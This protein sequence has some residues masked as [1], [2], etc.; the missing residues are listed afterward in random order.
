MTNNCMDQGEAS[1]YPRQCSPSYPCWKDRLVSQPDPAR[2]AVNYHYAGVTMPVSNQLLEDAG[3]GEVE[4]I[5]LEQLRP[6]DFIDASNVI[7]SNVIPFPSKPD[8]RTTTELID[9]LLEDEA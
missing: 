6:L 9:E 7:P 4:R 2:D 5:L 1:H 8:D 3:L